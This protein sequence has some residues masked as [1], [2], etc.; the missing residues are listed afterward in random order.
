MNYRTFS[1][2]LYI[3]ERSTNVFSNIDLSANAL[4]YV[5]VQTNWG[6]IGY[7]NSATPQS[8]NGGSY[9]WTLGA[10]TQFLIN[11]GAITIG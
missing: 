9:T 6:G 7:G 10:N 8:F 11:A 2:R 5:E 1:P 3:E 4:N